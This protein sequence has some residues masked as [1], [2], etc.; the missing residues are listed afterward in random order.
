MEFVESRTYTTEQMQEEALLRR[1][2]LF[3]DPPPLGG[4]GPLCDLCHA[5]TWLELGGGDGHDVYHPNFDVR[6]LPGVDV[7][8]D[9]GSGIPCHDGHA[10]K[11]KTI[12]LLNHLSYKK[13][14]HLL[15]EC[16]R[17]LRS[18]GTLFIMVTDLGFLI[19]R[20]SVEGPHMVWMTGVYGTRGDTYDDDFHY[21]GYTSQSLQ[22]E[23]ERCGFTDIQHCG[24]YN[25]W[26][27]KMSATKP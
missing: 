23:L 15:S 5:S 27:F 22:S 9:L 19:E 18:Q 8:Y 21:W 1:W 16:F 20:I 13:A 2:Q 3:G 25:R 12:H 26:E 4:T 10:E 24:Y 17:V 14:C 7:V 6:F 11:I